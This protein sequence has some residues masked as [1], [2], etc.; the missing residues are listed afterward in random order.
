MHPPFI[1]PCFIQHSRVNG[2]GRT[3]IIADVRN[4]RGDRCFHT[5]PAGLGAVVEKEG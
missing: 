2:K 3:I 5:R 4:R 1:P